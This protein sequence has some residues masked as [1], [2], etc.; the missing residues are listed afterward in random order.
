MNG[1]KPLDREFFLSLVPEV[2]RAEAVPVSMIVVISWMNRAGESRWRS[3]LQCDE[4]VSSVVG[5]LEM[6]KLDAIART[7][8]TGLPFRHP[9]DYVDPDAT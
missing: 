1:A 2:E 8:N 4:P 9:P 6:S 3:Y 5:L 7:P